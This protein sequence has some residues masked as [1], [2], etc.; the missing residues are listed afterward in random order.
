MSARGFTEREAKVLSRSLKTRKRV[1]WLAVLNEFLFDV[2]YVSV[3]LFFLI[4]SIN[5]VMSVHS[6]HAESVVHQNNYYCPGVKAGEPV[7]GATPAQL[8]K[9][10]K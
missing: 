7:M 9:L 1:Q 2:L 10:C 3:V 6:A 4:M 8:A 5:L